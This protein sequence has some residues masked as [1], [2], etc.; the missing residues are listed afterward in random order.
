MNHDNDWPQKISSAPW[1][2]TVGER[3]KEPKDQNTYYKII[4]WRQGRED[5][6]K[7]I[8]TVWLPEQ[9]LYNSISLQDNMHGEN[10]PRLYP[11]IMC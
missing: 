7:N 8:S 6:P 5:V 2:T 11:H 1:V 9:D 3:L 10:F 4:T